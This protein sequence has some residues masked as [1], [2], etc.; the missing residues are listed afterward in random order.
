M[1]THSRNL[2][3]D[4]MKSS[5]SGGKFEFFSGWLSAAIFF[6][7]LS[8]VRDNDDGETTIM[9]TEKVRRVALLSACQWAGSGNLIAGTRD[10]DSLGTKKDSR[11]WLPEPEGWA[12]WGWLP[13]WHRHSW[14]VGFHRHTGSQLDKKLPLTS[15]STRG[16]L[17][18]ATH[19]RHVRSPWQ[20]PS[21]SLAGD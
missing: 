12:L 15:P 11:K 18:P 9:K 19:F 6:A 8:C 4:L 13:G 20:R 3:G 17:P 14:L 16:W 5:H 10:K 1:L 7:P 2:D 21:A